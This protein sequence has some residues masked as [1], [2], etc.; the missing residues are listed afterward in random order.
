M[1][2]ESLKKCFVLIFS[3]VIWK[4][5]I[6]LYLQILDDIFRNCEKITGRKLSLNQSNLENVLFVV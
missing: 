5:E 4:T 3:Q 2:N 1:K 6:Y